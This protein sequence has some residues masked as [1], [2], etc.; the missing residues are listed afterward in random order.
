[1]SDVVS[2]LTAAMPILKMEGGG[3][4]SFI[5]DVKMNT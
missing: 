3:M 5:K 1:M 4:N 2:G